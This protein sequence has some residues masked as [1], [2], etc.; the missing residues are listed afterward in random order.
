MIENSDS[1]QVCHACCE[2]HIG[3]RIVFICIFRK[4]SSEYTFIWGSLS[5]GK[6][7]SVGKGNL[8]WLTQLINRRG[9][10]EVQLI[11]FLFF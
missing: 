8:L 6:W 2:R 7:M 1:L 3:S 11:F 10:G 9:G 4:Q 5:C